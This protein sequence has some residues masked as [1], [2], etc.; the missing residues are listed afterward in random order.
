MQ[1]NNTLPIPQTIVKYS[2]FVN[3]WN[4][5]Y[6]FNSPSFFRLWVSS[7][8]EYSPPPWRD[9]P[10]RPGDPA[11][12]EV[13]LLAT[14][15]QWEEELKSINKRAEC[16]PQSVSSL[17]RSVFFSSASHCR[18]CSDVAAVPEKLQNLA[19]AVSSGRMR[20]T[21]DK[22]IQPCSSAKFILLRPTYT[23][24][25]PLTLIIWTIDHFHLRL[26]PRS[27]DLCGI[28]A[29]R[30]KRAVASARA[31]S[32]ANTM[33][34]TD[35][36]S[37]TRNVASA[38]CENHLTFSYQ[39]WAWS[40]ASNPACEVVAGLGCSELEEE[41]HSWSHSW[42]FLGKLSA[43]S[44]SSKIFSTQWLTMAAAD[45]STALP[46]EQKHSVRLNPATD[47]VEDL[48]CLH[49]TAISNISFLSYES[50]PL[51]RGETSQAAIE[52]WLE[53][54]EFIQEDIGWL[55]RLSH[56]EFW[57]QVIASFSCVFYHVLYISLPYGLPHI[58]RGEMWWL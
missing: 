33:A 49:P 19:S 48:P 42:G 16:Q 37:A 3:L 14:Q 18:F 20:R 8:W 10:W 36:A 40:P 35:M 26:S 27:C 51:C 24:W 44:S 58:H 21:M 23:L 12:F 45:P 6:T 47:L 28:A 46:L 5:S 15:A 54:V 11:S 25:T 56:E 17:S 39:S 57:C 13:S 4:F 34:T 55:L 30:Y 50:P 29:R 38:S 2:I 52:E 43:L 22:R 32:K 41:C 53:R 1:V 9:P 7:S 31:P